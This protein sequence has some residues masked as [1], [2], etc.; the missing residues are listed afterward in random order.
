MASSSSGSAHSDE[1][2]L[3]IRTDYE[4]AEALFRSDDPAEFMKWFL[5]G[6][7]LIQGDITPL[8][9]V[10]AREPDPAAVEMAEQLR[11]ITK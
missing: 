11:R 2:T 4:T 6:R 7:I 1:A 9:A 3:S 8:M 10:Q 5:E